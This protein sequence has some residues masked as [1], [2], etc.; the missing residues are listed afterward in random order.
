MLNHPC[1]CLEIMD[2]LRY[3]FGVQL[4]PSPSTFLLTQ[5]HSPYPSQKSFEQTTE[6]TFN[7][8]PAN[9]TGPVDRG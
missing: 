2:F 5:G 9:I 4:L 7:R 3:L 6:I 1:V 8:R